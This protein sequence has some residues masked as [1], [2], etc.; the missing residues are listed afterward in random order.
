MQKSGHASRGIEVQHGE[1]AGAVLPGR[2]AHVAYQRNR[3][4]V[5]RGDLPGSHLQTAAAMGIVRRAHTSLLVNFGSD[6]SWGADADTLGERAAR[7][8][9]FMTDQTGS[10]DRAYADQ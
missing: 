8:V 5:S 2:E 7:L 1:V 9:W 4:G 10:T 3:K 6:P